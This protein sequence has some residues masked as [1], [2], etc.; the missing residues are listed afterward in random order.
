MSLL[1][2]RADVP[3]AVTV[4]VAVILL[5][6]GVGLF[7]WWVRSQHPR[8]SDP[9]H[10]LTP[11]GSLRLALCAIT[12]AAAAALLTS[13]AARIVY[14][15]DP[16]T[17]VVMNS[18]ETQISAVVRLVNDPQPMHPGASS[19]R[20]GVNARVEKFR[21]PDGESSSSIMLYIT[22]KGWSDLSRGDVVQ[23]SGRINSTFRGDP[24]F[25][26]TLR[27]NDPRVIE[28]PGGWLAWA[29]VTRRALSRATMGLSDQGKALVPGMSVGDDRAMSRDLKQAMRSS[30]LTHLTAVS[31]SHIAILLA[32]VVSVTPGTRRLRAGVTTAVLLIILALVGPE[33]SVLRSV[34]TASVGVAGLVLGRTGQGIS[35][36]SAI[37]T[38]VILVDPWAA[39]SL[40]FALSVAATLG[41]LGPSTALLRWMKTRVR[42]DTVTGKIMRRILAVVAIPLTCQIMVLP[43][44][45][46]L[47]DTVSIW[48]VMANVAV[49]PAV[50]PATVL[51][52]ATALTAPEFPQ[53][54]HLLAQAAQIFTG[55]IAGVARW[56]ND[57]PGAHWAIP[58]RSLTVLAV[59]AVVVMGTLWVHVRS[60][61]MIAVS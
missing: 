59:Y 43:I 38:V 51:S 14:N 18:K 33:P 58:G 57:L 5:T 15:C 8:R 20:Y 10:A 27:A 41:V 12:I 45:L 16:L 25:V 52:M 19:G 37:V 24:P 40:G 56:M 54:A 46:L 50:A 53:L 2:S 55:W 32:V 34:S 26:G 35:A 21:G 30:S 60:R 13:N 49:A 3:A 7:L 31:G 29:R 11:V 6:L 47:S 23:V 39:Q 1:I 44:L 4:C 22:G 48:S 36:L 9:V 17:R 28:R 42:D 61:G